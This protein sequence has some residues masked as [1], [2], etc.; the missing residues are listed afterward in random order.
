MA[1]KAGRLSANTDKIISSDD[2]LNLYAKSFEKNGNYLN[3]YGKPINK[4]LLDTYIDDLNATA[5][6]QN[7]ILDRA[8]EDAIA[9]FSKLYD[10]FLEKMPK[11]LT[12][13]GKE[14]RLPNFGTVYLINLIY[15]RSEGKFPIYDQFAH[16]AVK[17]LFANA[18]P[19]NIYIGPA[20]DKEEQ[21]KVVALYREYL[22]LLDKVFGRIKIERKLDQALWVYGHK[23]EAYTG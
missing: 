16:K 3:G 23:S 11:D 2:E 12:S 19:A 1:W 21:T 9:C 6:E 18:S 10:K 14:K 7:T 17:A 20:P 15:F 22:W 5:Q 8:G 13:D 4:K